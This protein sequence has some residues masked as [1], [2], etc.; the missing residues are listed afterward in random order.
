[1]KLLITA[2]APVIIL[3]FYI[4]FRDKYDKEP[5]LKLVFSLLAGMIITIPVIFIEEFLTAAVSGY[6]F[7]E[8]FVWGRA[9]YDAFIVAGF[10]EELFKAL[11]F[12][13]LVWRSKHFDEKFDGIVYAA[14]ISLGFAAV[15]NVLYSYTFGQ[16]VAYARAFTTIPAHAVFGITMGYFF[17]FAKFNTKKAV[18]YIL[19]GFGLAFLLHGIYDFLIMA[20]NNLLLLL[21]FPYV[22][23]LFRSAH[24]RMKSHSE[25]S[26]FNP[27][28]SE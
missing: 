26:R 28:N 7:Y 17:G 5:I 14:F 25:T 24:I 9:A 1:M 22:F 16:E 20:E 15:E 18:V 19:S 2:I 13:V 27:G 12:F 10:T 23:Y 21:F 8:G 11:A 3:M 6:S 4:Y